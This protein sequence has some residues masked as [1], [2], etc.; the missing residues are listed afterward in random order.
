MGLS[1]G[2]ML[3]LKILRY[4]EPYSFMSDPLISVRQAKKHAVDDLQQ[5][6]TNLADH[7][8]HT[9]DKVGATLRAAREEIG[10]DLKELAQDLCVNSRYLQAIE[11]GHYD[12][13]PGRAYAIGFV[14]A[15]AGRL[16]LDTNEVVNLFKR[17][18]ANHDAE[19]GLAFPEPVHER[20]TPVGAIIILASVLVVVVWGVF[21]IL[22]TYDTQEPG[23]AEVPN[24][25][26]ESTGLALNV[27]EDVAEDV[28]EDVVE[29][30]PKTIVLETQTA[31]SVGET[32]LLPDATK[33]QSIRV[34]QNDSKQ[35]SSI[36]TLAEQVTTPTKIG[37]ETVQL[38]TS[39]N[40]SLEQK[41]PKLETP[42]LETPKLETPKLE[43]PE[44][45]ANSGEPEPVVYGDVEGNV[46]VVLKATAPS[47]VMI[48]NSSGRTVFTK[49]LNTG[50]KYL[51]P[52]ISGMV[53]RT[54]NAGG[55][56]VTVDGQK[57]PSLGPSG[58][59]RSQILLEPEPLTAGIQ[60]IRPE[61]PKNQMIPVVPVYEASPVS[62]TKPPAA[63]EDN[64]SLDAQE[65]PFVSPPEANF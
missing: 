30:Q 17:E 25:L 20:K 47:W 28:V 1:L 62:Q 8:A 18:V 42:K 12:Q 49:T 63:S 58:S 56:V 13:M 59:V 35:L 54:G 55:L 38:D 64:N 41:T 53:L 3:I 19:V 21:T 34:L 51:V 46:R 65:E 26:A 32:E 50:D 57:V 61:L 7:S 11:S 39:S 60:Q 27:A 44:Q 37:T 52:N 15:Y 2:L 5:T 23:V 22:S 43:T 29:E 36:V 48:K 33:T 45:I 14:R 6:D 4:K 40:T 16:G 9:P 10:W 31:A 24:E